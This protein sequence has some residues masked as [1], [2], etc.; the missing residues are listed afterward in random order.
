MKIS[1]PMTMHVVS[2]WS[3][4][5][6]SLIVGLMSAAGVVAITAWLNFIE[7]PIVVV[8][9]DNKCLKVLNFKNGDGYNCQ[10]RD[11]VL[12]KYRLAE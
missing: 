2:T 9:A 10:D 5:I 7:L 1:K 12:R 11:V 3:L 8:D 6:A 4:L